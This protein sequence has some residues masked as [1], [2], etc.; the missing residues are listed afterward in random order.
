[1]EAASG[2]PH[3]NFE[4]LSGHQEYK[5]RIGQY[6]AICLLLESSQTI[7]IEQVGHRKNVYKKF[8]KKQD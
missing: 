1:M 2:N 8:P 6:R 4:R 3:A 5:I 7:Y